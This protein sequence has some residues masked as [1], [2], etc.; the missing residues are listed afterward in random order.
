MRYHCTYIRMAKVKKNAS[1]DIEK[2]DHSCNA[3]E[4]MFLQ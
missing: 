2:L 3:D 4:G 1:G